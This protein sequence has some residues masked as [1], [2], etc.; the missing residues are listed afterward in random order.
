MAD[1]RVV[2]NAGDYL[3]AAGRPDDAAVIDGGRPHTYGEL[4]QAAA[5]LAGELGRL[6]VPPGARIAILARNSFFWVAAYLAALKVGVAVPLSEQNTPADLAAQAEWV[7]CAAL[8]AD[9]RTHRRL[10]SA[11]PGIPVVTDAALES[12][13]PSAWPDT[14]TDPDANASLMFTS[15]T[16]S[17]PKAVQVTHANLRANTESIVAYLGLGSS[18]R[19]LVILPF[20]YCFGASLLHTHLFVGGSVVLCNTFTFPETAVDAIARESCTGF[21]GV[22]STFQLLLRASSYA[23]RGLPSLRLVQQAGGRLAP[24]VIR[25]LA[26]A[27]PASELFVMYGQTEATARLSYL[28]PAMLEAKLGSIGRGIPGVELRVLDEAGRPVPPGVPG[29]IWASGPSISPGYFRDP[30]ATAAKFPGGDLRTGD[31]ATVDEDGYLFIV[32]R[33]EDFIKSWGHR[34]S[35][36][37]VEEAALLHPGVADAAA[38]GLPD[39]E[40]GEAVALAVVGGDGAS[41]DSAELLAFLRGRL[42]KHMVPTSVHLLPALPL[43][44]NGKVSRPQLRSLLGTRGGE[45]PW[46]SGD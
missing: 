6:G 18:D 42:P 8:L 40:A 22:P 29:E 3:L 9:R 45:V 15:G 4:R 10:G 27:Q 13:G 33:S 37:Q 39:A 30:D 28:P 1:G 34:V 11:L 46:K 35:P 17:R 38:V 2:G 7:G 44:A 24:T 16:T 12:D 32:G 41:V 21:A 25:Q 26:A 43:N 19:M 36:Q 14:P 31:V 23:R 20:H 5:R